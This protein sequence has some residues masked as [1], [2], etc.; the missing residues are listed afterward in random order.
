VHVCDLSCVKILT[1]NCELTRSQQKTVLGFYT[2]SFS[3]R[4]H[5]EK[6]KLGC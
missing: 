1:S 6:Y 3:I 5:F 2:N 4:W